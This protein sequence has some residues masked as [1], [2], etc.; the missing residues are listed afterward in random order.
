MTRVVGS[1][2][3]RGDDG[4]SLVLALVFILI[5]GLFATVALA[6]S[7]STLKGG[8]V[9]R[10]RGKT[11]YTLDGGIDRALQQLRSDVQLP[12]PALCAQ[13]GDPSA[14]GSVTLNGMTSNWSCTLQAGRA[15]KSSDATQTDFAV[16]ITKVGSGGLTTSNA[17]NQPLI[18]NGSVY[19]NG[20]LTNADLPKD[21]TIKDGADFVSPCPRDLSTLTAVVLVPAADGRA[22]YKGCTDQSLA[23]AAGTAPLTAAPSFVVPAGAN[24][25]DPANLLNGVDIGSGANTCRVFYPGRYNAQPDLLDGD[26]YMV[27]GLYYFANIGSLN[28]G[29]D[30]ATITAGKNQ[31]ASDLSGASGACSSMTD[32][33]ALG[34]PEVSGTKASMPLFSYGATWVLGGNSAIS[35]GMADFTMFT[36]PAG[37]SDRPLNIVA[38]PTATN[39]YAP[40]T[41]GSTVISGFQNKGKATINGKVFIPSGAADFFAT[42][43]TVI[44]VRGGIV[45]GD[46][47]LAASAS[48]GDG[49]VTFSVSGTS[50]PPPPPFRTVKIVTTASGTTA[51]NTAVATISNFA[52]SALPP[53][54][55]YPVVVKS[56]RT[57]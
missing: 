19:M 56:W 48:I 8:Q 50:S 11:Q 40:I 7:E 38:Y 25:A 29:S 5:V 28:L 9:V 1:R 12:D 47:A 10:D 31:V 21:L 45:A 35:V 6:K 23:E 46:L 26:N 42:N 14:T 41:S 3:P 15:K 27:S 34:R 16:V 17:V 49:S 43:S 55:P 30:K 57:G 32:S 24:A 53:A 52:G 2:R 4:V 37:G 39:G 20:T 33:I 36:P 51:T 22:G 13:P 44:Q 18:I 54:L